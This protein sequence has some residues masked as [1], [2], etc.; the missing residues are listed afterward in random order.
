[1][2]EGGWVFIEIVGLRL[3][4]ADPA[5]AIERGERWSSCGRVGC[6]AVVDED[7]AILLADALHAMRQAGIGAQ[8]LTDCFIGHAQKAA[9]IPGSLTILKVVGPLK[10]WPLRL[11][12]WCA[13]L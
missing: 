6:L 11:L 2:A 9:D 8:G 12:F 13:P 3:P 10:L 5:D 1:M 7:D 4:A